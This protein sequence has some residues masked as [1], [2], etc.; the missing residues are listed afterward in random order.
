[1]LPVSPIAVCSTATSLQTSLY[2]EAEPDFSRRA[3]Q[4]KRQK[5]VI[6]K[7]RISNDISYVGWFIESEGNAWACTP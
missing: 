7:V 1:V 4:S 6:D 3:R 2:L 5:V